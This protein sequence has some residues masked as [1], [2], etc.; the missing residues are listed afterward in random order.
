MTNAEKLIDRCRKI[1]AFKAREQA[2]LQ[3]LFA[4]EVRARLAAPRQ[5][6]RQH[7]RP[8]PVHQVEHGP[9]RSGREAGMQ[10]LDK[11]RFHVPSQHG[12]ETGMQTTLNKIRSHRPCLDGWEALL[13]GLGKTKGDDEPLPL[14]KVLWINGLA[15]TLWCLRAVHGFGAEKRLLALAYVREVQHLM[16]DPRSLNALDVVE[17]YAR[18]LA[19]EGEL[20][21]AAQ[22]AED[23]ARDA[24]GVQG[25]VDISGAAVGVLTCRAAAHAA[26]AA[27]LVAADTL[28]ASEDCADALG[29]EAAAEAGNLW[30]AALEVTREA[31]KARQEVLLR[32]FLENPRIFNK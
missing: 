4:L 14:L 17:R 9:A 22:G 7:P 32:A 23:A 16:T 11:I 15:D 31:A 30:D 1:A 21:A 24:C 5:H 3:K 29:W 10:T 27:A 25:I 8:H 2:Q 19:T 20:D 12:L 26:W 28:L 6:P 18:S 13:R